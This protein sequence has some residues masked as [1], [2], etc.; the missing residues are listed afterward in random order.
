VRKFVAALK[1]LKAIDPKARPYVRVRL[2]TSLIALVT[3]V[4]MPVALLAALF[5]HSSSLAL[6]GIILLAVSMLNIA[7]AE[8]ATA[9]LL[10]KLGEWRGLDG[11][12]VRRAEHPRRFWVWIAVRA[13]SVLIAAIG[14]V[15]L[16][17]MAVHWPQQL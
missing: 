9:W 10:F 12:L 13:A 2:L 3:L 15:F 7:V 11:M 5:L 6:T 16:A 4:L 14:G 8:S 1:G 17:N